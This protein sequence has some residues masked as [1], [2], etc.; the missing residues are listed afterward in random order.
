M[1]QGHEPLWQNQARSWRS[2]CPA[3]RS[4]AVQR[5]AHEALA[6]AAQFGVL[7]VCYGR[8]AAPRGGDGGSDCPRR[9]LAPPAPCAAP[10]MHSADDV[11]GWR[12]D[13]LHAVMDAPRRSK[14]RGRRA[15]SAPLAAAGRGRRRRL[16]RARARPGRRRACRRGAYEVVADGRRGRPDRA[17]ARRMRHAPRPGRPIHTLRARG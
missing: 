13:W 5:S 1:P 17:R 14:G 16:R 3:L 15:A 4:E 8:V 9:S 12:R 10:S 2:G 6:A 11:A 7:V